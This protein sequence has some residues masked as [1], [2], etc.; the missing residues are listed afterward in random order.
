MLDEGMWMCSGSVEMI[1]VPS[2]LRAEAFDRK[3]NGGSVSLHRATHVTQASFLD[4]HRVGSARKTLS[5]SLR[6]TLS[7]VSQIIHQFCSRSRLVAALPSVVLDCIRSTRS[8][9]AITI[10]YQQVLLSRGGT[11]AVVFDSFTD[12]S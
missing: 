5:L 3:G 10:P 11:L 4:I 12:P 2:D 9:K 8:D 7:T 1:S 6:Q